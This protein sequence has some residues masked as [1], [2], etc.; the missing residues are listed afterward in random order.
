MFARGEIRGRSEESGVVI[1]EAAAT[2]F[3]F[4]LLLFGV[5]EFSYVYYQWNSATMATERGARIAAVSDPVASNLK[6]LTGLEITTNLPGD[7]MPSFDCTCNGATQTCTGTVPSGATACTYDAAAMRTIL[8]GRGNNGSAC[9]TGRNRGMCYYLPRL[10]AANI[11]V[12]Y[13]YT[14]MGYAGREAGPVPT[15]TVWLQNVRYSYIFLSALARLT[16]VTFPVRATSTV[17]GEDM[18]GS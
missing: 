17:S 6:T 2:I 3:V 1:I 7:T 8:L 15:I 10:T 5:I 9:V 13:Q 18:R 14:G 4:L 11:M 12:R 16:S